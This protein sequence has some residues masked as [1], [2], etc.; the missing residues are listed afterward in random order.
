MA[1][2]VLAL[3]AAL[4]VTGAAT[5]D[6]EAAMWGGRGR[7]FGALRTNTAVGRSVVIGGRVNSGRRIAGPQQ[8]SVRKTFRS[9]R[10]VTRPGRVTGTDNPR[11]SGTRRPRLPVI[12]TIPAVLPGV[13]PLH[14]PV[15]IVSTVPPSGT[16]GPPSLPTPGPGSPQA[17]IPAAGEQRYMPD[18]VLVSFAANLPQQAVVSI[19]QGQRLALLSTH[20]LPLIATTLYRFR[21]TDGRTVPVAIASIAADGRIAQVQPNYVYALQED[22]AA[23][24]GDPAQYVLDKLHVPQAHAVATGSQVRVAVIDSS[25]DASHPEL[26]GIVTAQF[27][28]VGGAD[29]PQRHGTAMASAIAAHGRLMGIAPAARIL[30]VR[31]FEATSGGAGSTTARILDGLQWAADS[32][33]RIVNMSFA[34]P[35]DPKLHDMLAAA[36]KKGI[37]AIAAAGNDGPQA[38][39]AYPA[40]YPEVIA[41]TATDA[42]D[43]LYNLANRGTY[44]AVAAP[45]VNILAAA[46]NSAYELTTGTSVAAAHVSGLAALLV[47]RYP[48]L[49]P[50]AIQAILIHTAKD[51]GPQGRDDEYGAGLVD[52]YA[53]LVVLPS[54]RTV[55]RTGN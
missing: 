52:A 42:D 20:R 37:V 11:R 27:D 12:V 28:A 51:L 1:I 50:D 23:G 48:G 2:R 41:V 5:E 36:R 24:S 10:T 18:E 39:P 14:P 21:I 8:F 6:A 53:A 4:A 47:E 54:Q 44:L 15:P 9:G 43:K 55:V 32:G 38:P 7:S 35:P 33:A 45:G 29:Q 25:I 49:D 19:A 34:G 22:G 26:Q 30:A 13:V 31:A 3:A 46:P 16:N 40:A 17:N